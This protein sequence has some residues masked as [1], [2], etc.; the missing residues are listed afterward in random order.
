MGVTRG[1]LLFS[2]RRCWTDSGAVAIIE[3]MMQYD[4]VDGGRMCRC[5]P[6]CSEQAGVGFLDP[7]AQTRRSRG[8]TVDDADGAMSTSIAA[9]DRPCLLNKLLLKST[10]GC[11]VIELLIRISAREEGACSRRRRLGCLCWRS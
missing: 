9:A 7:D 10:K 6:W 8:R 2:L 3:Y 1:L 5:V 11:G 4:S